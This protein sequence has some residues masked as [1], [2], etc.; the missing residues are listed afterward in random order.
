MRF[1]SYDSHRWLCHDLPNLVCDSRGISDS[2]HFSVWT[3]FALRTNDYVS[4]VH[5]SS[6]D[7]PRN[8][9]VRKPWNSNN[10]RLRCQNSRFLFLDS[11]FWGC[12]CLMLWA[13]AD[14]PNWKSR[15]AAVLPPSTTSTLIPENSCLG[16]GKRIQA[17][18][19]EYLSPE[20]LLF[21]LSSQT[22]SMACP[23]TLSSRITRSR[24]W[25]VRKP[26]YPVCSAW[27]FKVLKTIRPVQAACY[28][29]FWKRILL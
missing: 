15:P 13:R 6:R 24:V 23:S 12:M 26:S 18:I 29:E 19:W 3:G 21:W 8:F 10:G 16:T 17:T 14:V 1:L 25:H 22:V 5:D 20:S 28:V 27:L 11:C 9:H 4:D 7:W 2:F